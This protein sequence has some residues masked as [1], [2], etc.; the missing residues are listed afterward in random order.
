MWL[1]ALVVL[2]LLQA[3]SCQKSGD[4]AFERELIEKSNHGLAL[5][6][7]W[8]QDDTGLNIRFFDGR[9]EKRP[10]ECCM[11]S[12]V[13]ISFGRITAIEWSD[14][15]FTA[16]GLPGGHVIVMD[17]K[18]KT[19]VKSRL[20]VSASLV[21]LSPDHKRFA[22]LG[23]PVDPE[24]TRASYGLQITE[25]D[26]A[27]SRPL[28]APEVRSESDVHKPPQSLDWSPDGNLVLFSDGVEVLAI[29]VRTGPSRTIAK[30]HNA[31][32]S[33]AGNE[34]VY[35]TAQ[36]ATFLLNLN[37]GRSSPILANR[38]IISPPIWSPD[39][40]YLSFVERH[41]SITPCIGKY[42]LD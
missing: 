33:S 30:G 29:D 32:P 26:A 35:M 40:K 21:S 28:R 36:S 23:S 17:L 2:A 13:R 24:F 9:E 41:Y 10:I 31:R 7:V 11:R 5:A 14:P 42:I 34:I 12:S 20:K 18:G 25:M 6:T 4:A 1:F 37:T 38:E 3:T 15:I 39:G 19:I 8:N 16:K 22:F 27:T